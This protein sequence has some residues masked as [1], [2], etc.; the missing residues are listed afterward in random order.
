MKQTGWELWISSKTKLNDFSIRKYM[1]FKENKKEKS[2][3]LWN[4]PKLFDKRMVLRGTSQFFL[5][6]LI[7]LCHYLSSSLK[8]IFTY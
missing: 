1:N 4:V 6:S 2:N 5:E 7:F 8:N 3:L